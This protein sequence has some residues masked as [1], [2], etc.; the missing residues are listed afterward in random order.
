[1]ND[2]SPI[3]S[4]DARPVVLPAV[5][6]AKFAAR[7]QALIWEAI[8]RAEANELGTDAWLAD[9]VVAAA[10]EAVGPVLVR[11]AIRDV[12]RFR[13]VLPLPARAGS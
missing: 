4:P 3:A 1:M 13:D 11:R 7:V 10:V 5:E 2:A 9:Q 8:R 6:H 12:L